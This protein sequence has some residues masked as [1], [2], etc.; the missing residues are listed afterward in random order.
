MDSSL[1]SSADSKGF[2][3]LLFNLNQA[4]LDLTLVQFQSVVTVF[5]NIVVSL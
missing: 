4:S 3:F 1:W 2:L 5:K